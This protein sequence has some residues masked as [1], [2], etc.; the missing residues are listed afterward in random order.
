MVDQQKFHFRF[1]FGHNIPTN[2]LVVF[3]YS[4]TA[5]D[6]QFNS[7]QSQMS[8]SREQFKKFLRQF[9]FIDGY[10]SFHGDGMYM[11]E[12]EECTQLDIF[13]ISEENAE[14]VQQTYI[15]QYLQDD[16]FYHVIK[17]D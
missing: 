15:K 17:D 1:F 7:T 6:L 16:V 4:Q 14:L 3:R 12:E 9:E 2:N 10:T 8:V 13:E 11:S 5:N